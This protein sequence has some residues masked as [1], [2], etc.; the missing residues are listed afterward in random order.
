MRPACEDYGLLCA[1]IKEVA[2]NQPHWISALANVASLLAMSLD[3]VNWVG[4]YVLG[5]LL[6]PALPAD[7]LIVGPFS[8]NVACSRI[9][10]SKG[11]CGTAALEDRTLLVDDVHSFR[12][13]IA[14]DA[15]SASE[16]VVPLHADGRVIGV[17]DIDSPHIARF[18]AADRQ[19][20]ENVAHTL[21][22]SLQI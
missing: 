1:Q 5:S 7:E 20:L 22:E 10:F 3:D 6:D 9:P 18:A 2:A 16:I 11:V 4:F 12:G 8:G 19:G 14:C 17:L 15:A 13:H 21:E